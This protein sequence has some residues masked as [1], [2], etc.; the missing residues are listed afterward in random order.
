M[1]AVM[2]EPEYALPLDGE[3]DAA[4][5]ILSRISGEGNDRNFAPG[6]IL[7]TE[8]EKRD[9]LELNR[10]YSKFMLV[11]NT[12]GP[13]DLSP[14]L[15]VD[16]ILVLSQLGVDTGSA[17]ADLILGKAYPSGKLTTTW[18]AWDRY[19]QIGDFGELEDTCYKE[20]IYVGYRYFNSIGEKAL[21]PFGFGLS[22]TDFEISCV[23]VKAEGEHIYVSAAVKNTGCHPG[24]EVVQLYVSVPEGKLDQ[25]YQTLADF[26]K[27]KELAAG[28]TQNVKL[29][30]DLSDLASFDADTAAYILEQ[31]DYI[32]RIGN[33]SVQTKVCGVVKLDEDVTV[34]KVRSIG[35]KV[36][37]SDWKPEKRRQEDLP[38]EIVV[39]S[40]SAVDFAT[41]TV[42]YDVPAEVD[43]KIKALTDE[44]LA[45]L[46]VGAFNPKGG[47][48]SIIGNASQNVA[49]AA[50]ETTS[51]LKSKDF[52]PLVMAD[53]PAGLRLSQSY[54]VDEKGVHPI[55]ETMPATILDFM[56]A[57]LVFLT[58]LMNPKPKKN[59]EIRHQ[60]AT[61]IPIGTAIAQSW[62]RE[63][64]YI[65]GDIVGDEMERFG[66]HLWLAPAL[67][68]HESYGKGISH[69][70]SFG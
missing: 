35:G 22:Y 2:P 40:V 14:V 17:L 67:N 33:S 10:K 38:E 48:L 3:G 51:Q 56:P 45:Y 41:E 50:G 58:S 68:I 28:E 12:G 20:G 49:C 70:A 53:G 1:G 60:Y 15:E 8:T 13:V 24:K 55:G 31:G 65:C 30:F 47:A 42:S 44:E 57:P 29:C 7:L 59:A 4:I 52:E 18:T 9:I 43:T 69:R 32:L 6:D 16:N 23:D 5:Y 26:E 39:V 62:N 37:F 64:A 11:I 27:T 66:V 21:F 25:P 61:A 34:K 46:N 36:D 63:F 54:A 19:P